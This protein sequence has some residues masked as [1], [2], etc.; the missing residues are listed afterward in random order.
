MS[1]ACLFCKIAKKEVPSKILHEDEEFVGFVDANPQAPTHL[2]IIPRLHIETVNDARSEH[3]QL[4][5]RM[6]L[7]A[8]KIARQHQI[9]QTGYR[10]VV[11]TNRGAGQS[12]FHLHMHLLGGRGMH[13]PPG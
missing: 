6:F 12:V 7:V 9:D 10:L 8:Q 13:W 1:A 3:A 5:G 2:L 4:L 11:N